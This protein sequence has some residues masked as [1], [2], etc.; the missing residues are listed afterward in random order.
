LEL[1]HP[2]WELDHRCRLFYI[3]FPTFENER[4]DPWEEE[5]NTILSGTNSIE[6]LKR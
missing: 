3:I 6:T 1:D 2:R 4:R 5:R